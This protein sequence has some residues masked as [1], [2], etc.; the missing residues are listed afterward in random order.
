[1]LDSA[2][3][4]AAEER[5]YATL[6]GKFGLETLNF[7]GHRAVSVDKLEVSQH[8]SVQHGYDYDNFARA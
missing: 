3:A 1:V 6:A 5:R 7:S 4:A 8:S 2:A